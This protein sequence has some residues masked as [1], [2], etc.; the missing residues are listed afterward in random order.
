MKEPLAKNK[1]LLIGWDA[2]DW[3]II[4]PLLKQ[5]KLPAFQKLIKEGC[6]GKIESLQPMLSPLLWTSIATGVTADKHGILGFTEVKAD[7][8]GI[9]PITINSRKVKTIWN[10]LNEYGYKC[11]V[12]SWWPSYPAEEINGI[13]T[14]EHLGYSAKNIHQDWPVIPGSVHPAHLEEKIGRMR[15]HPQELTSAQISPFFNDLQNIN[16]LDNELIS[17]F[18]SDLARDVTTHNIVTWALEYTDWDF[19]AVYYNGLDSICHSFAKYMPPQQKSISDEAFLRYK[20]VV[21]HTYRFYDMMLER[22][23]NLIP[24]NCHLVLVSDHGFNISEKR[25]TRLPN[26]PLAPAHEHNPYGIVTLSGPLIKKGVEINGSSLLDIAPTI[27]NLYG[28]EPESTIDGKSLNQIFNT[29]PAVN[30]TN[31]ASISQP[32]NGNVKALN[33]ET[34]EI[35]LEQLKNLG[36][37]E[38]GEFN[39]NDKIKTS[40]DINN[41]NLAQVFMFKNEFSKAIPILEGLIKNYQRNYLLML[42]TC[43]EALN[44]T[45]KMKSLVK[46]LAERENTQVNLINYLYGRYYSQCSDHIKAIDCFLTLSKRHTKSVAINFRIAREYYYQKKYDKAIEYFN[47]EEEVS[48][49]NYQLYYLRALCKLHKKDTQGALSDLLASVNLKNEQPIAHYYIGSVLFEFKKYHEAEKA[50]MLSFLEQPSYTTFNKL[51]ELYK[52]T[53]NKQ[54]LMALEEKL[55]R[56]KRKEV[57]VVSGLPRSG[58]S[59]MMQLL[60][61]GG[62][63]CYTDNERLPDE[64]NPNGYFEHELVKKLPSDSS[65]LVDVENKCIKVVSPLLF[66]LPDIYNY[67]VIL[68]ER[69]FNE[70][71]LSQKRMLQRNGKKIYE[72]NYPLEL[73]Q[74]FQNNKERVTEWCQ[75]NDN[76]SCLRVNFRDLFKHPEFIIKNIE[77]FL[78]IALHKQS[79]AN[80]INPDLYREKA[81]LVK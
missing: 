55:Q 16:K 6:A 75:Q 44:K 30:H 42:F 41:F 77:A 38:P 64:N 31:I 24:D 49:Q 28:I 11:N 32:H 59:L 13:I 34:S 70:I 7:R 60:N 3:E 73:M 4:N 19:T 1:V 63:K 51:K 72:E 37:I 21:Y 58:T 26:E 79:M 68:M 20:N 40:I 66:Y 65:W 81:S 61:A 62:I 10:I 5:N 74:A 46:L 69:D 80:I 67:K 33:H 23:L 27:L 12:I 22:L 47:A 43:Y 8:S 56:T 18:V 25:H 35:L 45:N 9:Q 17:S 15:V 52:I 54:A 36:Y 50:L 76:V 2:A 29:P 14:T 57:I 53:G 71:A 39:Q 78:N 48:Q